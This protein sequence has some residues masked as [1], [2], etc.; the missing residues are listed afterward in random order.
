MSLCIAAGSKAV[1]MAVAAFTL[2]WTHSVEKTRWEED[3]LVTPAGLE[4][5]EARVRGSGAGMEPAEGARLVDGWWIYVPRLGPQPSVMLAASGATGAGWTLCA[6]G[7]CMTLGA[8]AGE[9][10]VIRA[11]AANPSPELDR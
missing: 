1:T 3:W 8:E 6:E 7:R 9:T 10:V 11:C 5:V 4:I 2:S